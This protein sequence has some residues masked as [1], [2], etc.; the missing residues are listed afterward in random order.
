[1]F[2]RSYLGYR[3]W[4][5]RAVR[6]SLQSRAGGAHGRPFS[7][8][9]KTPF[10]PRDYTYLALLCSVLLTTR[11]PGAALGGRSDVRQAAAEAD[12]ELGG[13]TLTE[14]R[15][16]GP[17]PAPTDRVGSHDEDAGSVADFADD[18]S[19]EALLWVEQGPGAQP[20]GRALRDVEIR[21]DLIRVAS[22]RMPIRSAI[23]SGARSSKR[24]S[25]WW[26]TY[27]SRS[28][29]AAPVP[30]AGGPDPRGELRAAP[31]DPG[32]GGGGVRP[33]GRAERH[34][35]PARRHARPSRPFAVAELVDGLEADGPGGR[36][37]RPRRDA[38]SRGCSAALPARARRW[39]KEYT[40]RP[41]RLLAEAEDLLLSMGLLV[42]AGDGTLALRAVAGRYA[43]EPEVRQPAALTLEDA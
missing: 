4:S 27:R 19:K 33:V 17:C 22:R 9:A 35:L 34:P 20:S 37:S 36:G 29:V 30:A 8:R 43:P 24:R 38:R 25:S 23:P 3:L 21:P 41:E 40:E 16:D 32:R 14:R 10:S 12:I 18:P 2:F 13:D 5:T 15:V 31:R 6:P 7:G 28:G 42:D 26:T 11:Q 39:S 1:M